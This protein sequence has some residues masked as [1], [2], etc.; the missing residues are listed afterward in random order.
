[1]NFFTKL[2]NKFKKNLKIFKEINSINKKK[3]KFIFYSE[4]KSY[5][6]YGYLLIEYLSKNYPGEVYYVSSD[7]EDNI[8]NLNVKN[9]FIGKAFFLKYFFLNVKAENLFITLTD[10]DNSIIIRNKYVKNYVYY[11]HGAI[12]TTKAYTR[13]AFDNYDTI[14]CNGDYQYFEIKKREQIENLKEKKLIKFGYN[15]FDYLDNKKNTNNYSNEILV[16]PSWNKN[17]L[18][19]I[20]ED[21]EKIIENI[22]KSG[23][24]VRFRPHP[25]TLKRSYD[26]M[27]FYKNKFKGNNFIFDDHPE[28]LDAMEKAKCLITDNSGISIE[29]IMIFKK[30][31]IYYSDFDKIHNDKFS[32]YKDLI[33]MDEI[34][35]KKFGY[36][37]QSSQINDI[38]KIL[39]SAVNEFNEKDIDSFLKK[40]FYNFKNT[41]NYFKNN[42]SDICK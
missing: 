19:F 11:F 12:S 42:I 20:N 32:K 4:N 31:V 27:N 41:I 14:L 34:V 9:I 5:L 28:N 39:N 33:T 25:E 36:I 3:P 18:K 17:K 8:K 24:V 1:M 2:F 23:F 10:L 38:E 35:K 30:P 16:A 15:Y 6:K 7:I 26:L 21:F 22:I 29:Y 40:N 37:I 13:S